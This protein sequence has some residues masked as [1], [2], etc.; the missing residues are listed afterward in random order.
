MEALFAGR[1]VGPLGSRLLDHHEVIL[2]VLS[3]V[4]LGKVEAFHRGGRQLSADGRESVF[5][6]QCYDANVMT[7]GPTASQTERQEEHT[8]REREKE[9]EMG[10]HE[11]AL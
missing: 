4:Q 6:R 9:K 11:T 5:M 3:Q 7:E 10:G 8:K 1:R 2:A